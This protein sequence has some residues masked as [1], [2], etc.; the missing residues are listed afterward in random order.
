M[1]AQ[2]GPYGM[3]FNSSEGAFPASYDGYAAHMVFMLIFLFDY[4]FDHK[5]TT[6]GL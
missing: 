2:G 1:M 3:K 5:A 6:S 4:F